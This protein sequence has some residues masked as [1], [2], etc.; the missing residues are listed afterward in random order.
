M[1]QIYGVR[2]LV[3]GI[4]KC[5]ADAV[6]LV[7]TALVETP[8]SSDVHLLVDVVK[9]FSMLAKYRKR[10]GLGKLSEAS[11]EFLQRFRHA[12]VHWIAEH[13]DLY[14]LNVY[15]SAHDVNKSAPSLRSGGA[16]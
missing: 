5:F 3:R 4:H 14:I 10:K 12:L 13:T 15:Q 11:M 7:W 8:F 1:G 6:E 16:D 2:E 9:C